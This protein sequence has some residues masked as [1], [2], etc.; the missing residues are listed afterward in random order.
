[1]LGMEILQSRLKVKLKSHPKM[2]VS[3]IAE[4]DSH[5]LGELPWALAGEGRILAL[6]VNRNHMLGHELHG[7]TKLHSSRCP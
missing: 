2:E 6:N 5:C 1:M 7:R 4:V 3:E